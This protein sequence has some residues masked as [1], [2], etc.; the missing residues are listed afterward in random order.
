MKRFSTTYINEANTD[1]LKQKGITNNDYKIDDRGIIEELGLLAQSIETKFN[2]KAY[3]KFPNKDVNLKA[4]IIGSISNNRIIFVEDNDETNKVINTILGSIKASY[5]KKLKYVPDVV[6][7]KPMT[8]VEFIRKHKIASNQLLAK[9]DKEDNGRWSPYVE[10]T[11][12]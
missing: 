2:V 7:W 5:N 3:L 4:I 8:E 10:E 11:T 9:S 1:F 6:V 12:T